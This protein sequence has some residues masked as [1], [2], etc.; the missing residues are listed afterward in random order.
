M[1]DLGYG[2]T[3]RY[4][5]D[6]PHAYAAGQSYWPEPLSEKNVRP[7]FY[8]PNSRGLEIK[9]AEKMAFLQQLENEP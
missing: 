5:H 6:E 8:R 7:T 9:L 2:A 3:Y 4:A 1:S